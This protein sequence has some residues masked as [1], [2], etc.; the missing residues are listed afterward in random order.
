M[1]L[2]ETK[3][4]QGIQKLKLSANEQVTTEKTK[5]MLELMAKVC[6]RRCIIPRANVCVIITLVCDVCD[7]WSVV[8]I[9]MC[10]TFMYTLLLLFAAPS[11]ATLNW[12]RRT[13]TL[14][15]K[16]IGLG[17]TRTNAASSHS[18]SNE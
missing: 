10:R 17:V 6:I 12:R 4:L 9:N 13:G 15:L 8:H 11:V 1:L 3:A 2:E 18:W 7:G 5:K 16:N 14:T